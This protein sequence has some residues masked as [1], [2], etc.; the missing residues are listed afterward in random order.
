MID[1]G[2]AEH[3]SVIAMSKRFGI[4]IHSLY[5]H[6]YRHLT[7]AVLTKLASGSSYAVENLEALRTTE[8]ERLL[9][10]AVEV[11]RRLYANA[12]SAEE[13]GDFKAASQSYAFILRSLELIGKLLSQ[14]K[15]YQ[16]TTINQ[17]TISPDYLKLRAA[18]IQAL[19][20]YPDARRAVAAVLREIE[21]IDP[22]AT[23]QSLP[24]TIPRAAKVSKQPK[25]SNDASAS[26]VIANG[27]GA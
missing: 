23:T 10:N 9:S 27:S 24:L 8:A 15:G 11:R 6:R 7:P 21:D 19:A 1:V 26:E 5:R 3:R 17:L 22:S 13:V 18:L 20:P 12:E 16:S 25:P 14:F 4:S 2:L